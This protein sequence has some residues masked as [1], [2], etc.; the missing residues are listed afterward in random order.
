M[1]EGYS[2]LEVSKKRGTFY[3][4]PLDFYV[5]EEMFTAFPLIRSLR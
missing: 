5:Y 3:G 1:R 2:F 4:T